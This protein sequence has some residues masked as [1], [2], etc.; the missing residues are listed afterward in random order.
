ME[1]TTRRGGPIMSTILLHKAEGS[2]ANP[3]EAFHEL[4]LWL[5]RPETLSRPVH[6]VERAE[7]S[8]GR[9]LLR[10]LLEEHLRHR[11]TGDVGKAIEV[12]YRTDTPI[13]D[14]ETELSSSVV[15][16]SLRL[17]LTRS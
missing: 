8:G 9:E 3:E 4:R 5:H 17:V 15:S 2:L 11:G 14:P 13:L 1:D 7:E 16:V 6:E 12:E 10:Q